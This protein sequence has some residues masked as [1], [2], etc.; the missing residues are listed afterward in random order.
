[1]IQLTQT[2]FQLRPRQQNPMGTLYDDAMKI[3]TERSPSPC[4]SRHSP[5]PKRLA[6]LIKKPSSRPLFRLWCEMH[7]QGRAPCFVG[8][9][10]APTRVSISAGSSSWSNSTSHLCGQSHEA[11]GEA[12]RTVEWVGGRGETHRVSKKCCN[13]IVLRQHAF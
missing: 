2:R 9:P 4:I 6:K 1:M 10:H 3:S 11:A 12:V 8:N 13:A 5:P 7:R